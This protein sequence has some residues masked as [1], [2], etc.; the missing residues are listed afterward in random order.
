[1]NIKKVTLLTL[2][3]VIA[4]S[5]VCVAHAGPAESAAINF[6]ATSS[7]PPATPIVTC[8]P[9]DTVWVFWNLAPKDSVAN[10]T[11]TAPDT[12]VVIALPNTGDGSYQFTASQVGIY[13]CTASVSGTDIGTKQIASQT[14]LVLPESVIGG[15]AAIG[16]GLAAFGTFR[17]VRKAQP[18]TRFA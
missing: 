10:I 13:T 6:Y 11:L 17:L 18:K 7:G 14:L 2:S 16:A 9:G 5:M 8:N 3:L 1:M 12:T 4:L 15:I